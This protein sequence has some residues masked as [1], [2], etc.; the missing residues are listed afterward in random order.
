MLA[1]SILAME[2]F[3]SNIFLAIFAFMITKIRI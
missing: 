2:A 3:L 1:A